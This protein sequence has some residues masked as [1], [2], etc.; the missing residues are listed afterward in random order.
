M[1]S[2]QQK[3]KKSTAS[4]AYQPNQKIHSSPALASNWLSLI[5]VLVITGIVFYPSLSNGFVNWDDYPNIL[6]NKNV[7]NFDL[8]GIFTEPV[9]GGYN[10]LTILTFAIEHSLVGYAP[11]LY[12]LDNLLLHLVCTFFVFQILKR[13]GLSN[14]ACAIGALLFGIHPM[15]VESV[16]WAT[17][18]KDV[19]FGAFYLSAL[20]CYIR[21]IQAGS[22]KNSWYVLALGLHVLA[23][24]SKIQAVALPLSMLAVD[25]LQGRSFNRK[26]IFEKIPFFVLS[27]AVGVT[28]LI[29]LKQNDSFESTTGLNFIERLM[30][31]AYTYLVYIAKAVFPWRMSPLYPYPHTMPGYFYAMPVGVAAIVGILY[32][33]FRNKLR[34]VVF[35]ILF[36]TFNVV[37]VLQIV[38]AG[39]GYLADRFTYIPYI[40]FFF[41]IAY[42]YDWLTKKDPGVSNSLSVG[43]AAYLLIFGFIT[44]RQI[45]IWKD[46]ET[47]W[48]HVL[49]YYD[50]TVTA[51]NNR[52]QIFR[53]RQQYDRALNDYNR[54][55]ALKSNISALNSRGL[56]YFQMDQADKA[57]ADYT[58]AIAIDSTDKEI[59]EVLINR[60]AV[61]GKTRQFDKAFADLNL[62]LA[63]DPKKELGYRNRYLAYMDTGNLPKALEDI[64]AYLRLKP[65]QSDA[66]YDRA[67][68]KRALGDAKGSLPDFDEAIRLAGN[69][70]PKLG[71]FYLERARTHQMLGNAAA[72]KEDAI[73]A[74]QRGMQVPPELTM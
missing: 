38:G 46:G 6:D 12:H 15:R 52:G 68:V 59:P 50:N 36:F 70:S 45:G 35:A 30:V 51:W 16:A 31:G 27:F 13:L 72:A 48:T 53:D 26:V 5:A 8:K 65:N 34:A 55:I 67:V 69:Q 2:K 32:Y 58:Q 43:L 60:G 21:Y 29:F 20:W 14:T 1:A 22:R 25:Y 62:G 28:G 47:L 42:Y 24:F 49:Q 40:G 66:I 37:F 4:K 39:Q 44:F 64:N 57:I 7:E 18:R 33:A 63:R 61:Y 56:I 9:I 11:F 17:E 73:Q 71:M 3:N 23:L 41:L 54:S 10:P 74:Q 19:L